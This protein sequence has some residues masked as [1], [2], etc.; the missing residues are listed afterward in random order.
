[1]IRT[2]H[3][4][5][6]TNH[7]RCRGL[8]FASGALAP[9]ALAPIYAWPILFVS[10]PLLLWALASATD[11]RQAFWR[12]WWWGLG[13]FVAGIYWVVIALTVDMA[14]FGWMIPIALLGLCG[15]LALF[16][17]VMGWCWFQLK[18][19]SDT[20][21]W[22]LFVMLFS[23]FEWLRGHI[24]TGFPWN[25]LGYSWAASDA[26]AQSASLVGIYG[27]TFITV[28]AASSAWLC[29][30]HK[31]RGGWVVVGFL[32]LTAGLTGWGANR[33]DHASTALS[34]VRVRMVQANVSQKLK[35]SGNYMQA[36]L[37]DHVN[38]SRTAS[39][40]MPDVI[41]W[42]E[43]AFPFG[44]SEGSDWPLELAKI[45]QPGQIL[46]TGAVMAQPNKGQRKIYNGMAAI[47]A[48]GEVVATQ[49][50]HHLVPFGEY[51]PLRN[52]LPTSFTKLTAGAVDFSRGAQPKDVMKLARGIYVLPLICYEAIFPA[53]GFSQHHK[54]FLLNLTNDG[55]YGSSSGPYQHRDAARFRAIEQ[56]M[57]M[58]RVAN[59]GISIAYDGYG[60]T[61]ASIPLNQQGIADVIVPMPTPSKTLYSRIGSVNMY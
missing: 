18:R 29:L 8:I 61:L 40:T 45:L 57:P 42:P 24:F 30:N 56:G 33:L 46:V 20:D 17:A 41:I 11:A 28:A 53:Y 14:R 32:V 23:G 19:T 34:H 35:W 13:F 58:V 9:L 31:R 54:G 25:L 1:M 50:K 15:S 43:S 5:L 6:T 26:S 59:T 3:T 12:G 7:W 60:R 21:N 39:V 10:L 16:F 55:W 2:L 38:L 48:Q 4:L 27:L 49:Y 37:Q 47:N 51:L 44:L 22:L 36:A 52:W